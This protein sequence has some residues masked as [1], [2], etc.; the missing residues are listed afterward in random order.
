MADLT[1]QISRLE[2]EIDRLAAVAESCRKIILASKAA[3]AIGAL[4]LA[5]TLLGLI[6]FDPTVV[7]GSIAAVLGGIVAGG[8]NGTTARQA[9]ADMRAAEARRAELIGQLDFERVIDDRK[10]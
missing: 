1:E 2:A 6:R 9:A 8:S 4:A 10:P 5:A 7:I 3:V